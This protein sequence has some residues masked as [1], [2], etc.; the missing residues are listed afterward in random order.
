MRKET[1]NK[2]FNLSNRIYCCY[3]SA[4][5]EDHLSIDHRKIVA[6]EMEQIYE[7]LKE[8]IFEDSIQDSKDKEYANKEMEKFTL[9]F[10]YGRE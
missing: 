3:T 7:K 6:R 5:Y 8:I 4:L 9:G 2:L 1:Y 10:D